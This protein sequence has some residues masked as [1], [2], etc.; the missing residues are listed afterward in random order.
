MSL[1]KDAL[2][3]CK[4]AL[5]AEQLSAAALRLLFRSR[6]EERTALPETPMAAAGPGPRA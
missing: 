3:I 6:R 1:R 5:R 2:T 4:A